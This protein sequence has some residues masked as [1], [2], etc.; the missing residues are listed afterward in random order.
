MSVM[1]IIVANTTV[2][3]FSLFSTLKA[4]FVDAFWPSILSVV[5][6]ISWGLYSNLNRKIVGQENYDAVGLFMIIT[7]VIS[8]AV[9]LFVQEPQRFV[10]QQLVEVV[11]MVVFS[12]FAATM[13]W[14]ISM[15]KGN[16][17]MVIFA[18]NFLPVISTILSAMLLN[19][20]LTGPVVGGS[21]L[22]VG[23]TIWCRKC[24]QEAS[25][26]RP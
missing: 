21:L 4:M 1:G 15:Q 7:G 19:V 12:S 14:N 10:A 23:G 2:A 11:Y 18:A 17:I 25:G 16:H 20:E 6:C 8:F 26:E 22:V 24:V 3:D 9:T 5:S 13:F